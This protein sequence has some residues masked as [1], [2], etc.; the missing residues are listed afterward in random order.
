MLSRAKIA[1]LLL[2]ACWVWLAACSKDPR[3]ERRPRTAAQREPRDAA[4][5]DPAD[6]EPGAS[7]DAAASERG[8][9]GISAEG[10]EPQDGAQSEGSEPRDAAAANGDASRDAAVSPHAP[11]PRDRAASPGPADASA[12]AH[13]A[14]AGRSTDTSGPL[15]ADDD[16]AVSEDDAGSQ[17][18]AADGGKPDHDFFSTVS[19]EDGASSTP[20]GEGDLWA[21][22]WADDGALYVAAGDGKG[23]SL[24]ERADV[25]V[26]RIDGSPD[27]LRGTTLSYGAAVSSVWSGAS[28]NRKPTGMLCS[29]GDLYLAVQDLRRDTFSDAPAAT[30]VRSRDKGKSWSWDRSAPMFDQ[31][32]F[33]TIMFLDYGKDAEHAPAEFAYA[34]GIDDNW[35][36]NTT[37]SPPTRLYLARMPRTAIQDRAQWQFWTGYDAEGAPRWS[38]D[39]AARAPVLEDTRRTYTTPL[40]PQQYFR[41]M[42]VINQGGIVYN[43]P[44]ARYIYTSWTEFTFELYEAPEP[45]GPWRHFFSKDLGVAPWNAQ[46]SGGYATT[47][48]SKFISADGRSMWLQSNAWATTGADNYHFSLRE[49]RVTPWMP[50]AASNARSSTP[51]STAEQGA[52]VIGRTFRLGTP[53]SLNDGVSADQSEDSWSGDTNTEDYWG[54][55]WPKLLNVNRVR[56]T[57]GRRTAE[58]GWFEELTVQVRRGRQWITVTGLRVEP[59]YPHDVTVPDHTTYTLRF[60]A[61]ITDGVRLY[62]RPGGSGRFTSIAELSVTYE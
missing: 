44:L 16:P 52:V 42:T 27:A 39:I 19:I 61:A 7:L 37:R 4:E 25:V 13:S 62:G 21:S 28:Y 35:A 24:E 36:F 56:Y 6:A 32:A 23:F 34:Y 10:G 53:E 43:A 12:P 2:V 3:D 9:A 26:G 29:G 18:P 40:D 14:D 1:G 60:D 41:N 47:L 38:S 57:T 49:V 8:D 48:P 22:C 33:T 30:I 51:L 54:Y 58:G 46:R 50:S 31:H 5:T 11:Q 15:S 20:V 59:S 45:W 17:V 55:T